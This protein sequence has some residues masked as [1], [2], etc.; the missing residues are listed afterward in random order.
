MEIRV[1]LNEKETKEALKNKGKRT[2]KQVIIG[3]E[4]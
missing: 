1:N 4:K 2:W 3:E